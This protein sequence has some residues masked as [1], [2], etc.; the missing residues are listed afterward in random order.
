MKTAMKAQHKTILFVLQH[1]PYGSHATRETLDAALAAA[2]FEQD[3]QLLFSGEGIWCL[4]AGQHSESIDS[5][6]IEKILQAL[7]YYDI[8]DVYVDAISLSERQLSAS[9]LAIA[10]TPL[11]GA[12]IAALLQRADCVLAL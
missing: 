5:K 10:A 7:A 8:N 3:V 1:A 12:E 6:N 11:A 9:D 2:A 4:L